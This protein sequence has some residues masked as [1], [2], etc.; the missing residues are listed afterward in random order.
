VNIYPVNQI[1]DVIKALETR[2]ELQLAGR[3]IIRSQLLQDAINRRH[4]LRLTVKRFDPN[5]G[6]EVVENIQR[7]LG[8]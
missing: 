8:W 4:D 3:T 2:G 1:R 7:Y 5:T 6:A